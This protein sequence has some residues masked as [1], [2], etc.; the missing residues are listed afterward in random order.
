MVW[1]VFETGTA[2]NEN[3]ACLMHLA[4]FLI[5]LLARVCCENVYLVHVLRLSYSSWL[6]LERPSRFFLLTSRHLFSH[7]TWL[8]KATTA[9]PLLLFVVN[10][11]AVVSL[12][13]RFHARMMQHFFCRGYQPFPLLDT[14]ILLL[15]FIVERELCSVCPIVREN[16]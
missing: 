10:D 7:V 5:Q 12:T 11:A 13:K 3:A 6:K 16:K 9:V 15:L 14:N 1:S 4:Y 2:S 8:T